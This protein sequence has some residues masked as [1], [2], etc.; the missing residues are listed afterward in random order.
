MQRVL[1]E[2]H[3]LDAMGHIQAAVLSPSERRRSRWLA[4]RVSSSVVGWLARWARCGGAGAG[5]GQGEGEG[6]GHG[7]VEGGGQGEGGAGAKARDVHAAM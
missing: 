4:G 5:E 7:G 1:R 6:G 3:R 2:E